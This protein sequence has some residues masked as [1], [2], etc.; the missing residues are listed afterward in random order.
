MNIAELESSAFLW[1]YVDFDCDIAELESREQDRKSGE[2]PEAKSAGFELVTRLTSKGFKI[3]KITIKKSRV[4]FPHTVGDIPTLIA[5]IVVAE[6]KGKIISFHIY[7]RF[8]G[9]KSD[10]EK[11]PDGVLCSQL[12]LWFFWRGKRFT[13]L[14]EFVKFG[15]TGIWL[16]PSS[17]A[18]Q[19]DQMFRKEILA[20]DY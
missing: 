9:S 8:L 16:S 10:W 3:L 5:R 17:E 18:L 14:W 6:P 12:G 19:W 13:P 20:S 2:I 4:G 7:P 1:D 11:I 15:D